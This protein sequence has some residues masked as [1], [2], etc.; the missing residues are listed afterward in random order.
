MDRTIHPAALPWTPR[1]LRGADVSVR[2]RPDGLL[3]ARVIHAPLLGITP[4]MLA[5][6]F[7]RQEDTVDVDGTPRS[8]FQ[9]EHP[10]HLAWRWIDPPKVGARFHR[11]LRLPGQ[12]PY[13][14]DSVNTVQTLDATGFAHHDTLAGR[15]WATEHHAFKAGPS[16]VVVT[17]QLSV[18]Y[19]DG[20]AR[21]LANHAW[22]P[23]SHPLAKGEAWLRH[24][25]EVVGN[26]GHALPPHWRRHHPVADPVAVPAPRLRGERSVG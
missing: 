20:P 23:L 17:S 19:A 1:D 13:P 18:G 7:T 16:G 25:V 5:W 21:W 4:E 24:T 6:W 22:R 3:S 12:P 8:G 26:I 2:V 10:D 15:P 14:I 11:C 9:A